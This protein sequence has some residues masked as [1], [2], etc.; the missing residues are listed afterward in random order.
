MSL[1]SSLH[2]SFL[3]LHYSATKKTRTTMRY[4]ILPHAVIM[5][6][7][8]QLAS[9]FKGHLNEH[10]ANLLILSSVAGCVVILMD[11]ICQK[12][13]L[14][15]LFPKEFKRKGSKH[16]RLEWNWLCISC[17]TSYQILNLNWTAHVINCGPISSAQDE[18]RTRRTSEEHS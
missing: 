4:S 12:P 1:Q 9:S 3:D 8:L 17:C 7:L 13:V 18:E 16:L 14:A 10:Y 6:L 2:H 15:Y 11:V 5:L